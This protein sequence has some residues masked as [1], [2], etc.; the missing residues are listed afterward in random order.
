MA[1]QESKS[2]ALG[3]R[4]L[5]ASLKLICVLILGII[6]V[7]GLWPFHAPKNKVR[8]L[9]SENG[10]RLGD[11][12]SIVSAGAFKAKGDTSCSLEIWIEPR[13]VAYSGTILAFYW[14]ATLVAPFELRQSLGDLLLQRTNL[15]ELQH[16][17]RSKMYV[18]DLLTHA[19]PVFVTI[20]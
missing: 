16:A 4:I 17:R 14:P 11:Y 18:D 15:D 2:Q 20:S 12:G 10:L 6:L 13:L 3:R 1:L 19:K 8:W 7:A 9:N 5:S